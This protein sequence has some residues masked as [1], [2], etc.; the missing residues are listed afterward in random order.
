MADSQRGKSDDGDGGESG[1]EKDSDDEYMGGDPSQSYEEMDTCIA[2]PS[3]SGH[4]NVSLVTTAEVRY[5]ETIMS[6]S[7][8][9]L[10]LAFP[11]PLS[12]RPHTFPLFPLAFHV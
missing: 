7:P 9:N 3:T 4:R 11:R 8:Q 12:P 5:V 6:R 1:D 10:I 2:A